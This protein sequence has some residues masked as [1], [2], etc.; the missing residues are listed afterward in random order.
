MIVLDTN[1]ISELMRKVPD[2]RVTAWID[3]QPVETLYLATISAAELRFGIA[4]APRGKHQQWLEEMLEE[5]ILP[6]FATRMLPFDLAASRAYAELM[7]KAR[8]VGQG[9]PV[10][11][12]YIAATAAAN[13]M[14]IATRNTRHFETAGLRVVNPWAS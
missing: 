2:E 10:A 14:K 5:E 12:G 8:A 9:I 4:V 13:G 11:D 1:V 7:A 3:A 6:S